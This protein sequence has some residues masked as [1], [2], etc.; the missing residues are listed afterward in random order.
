MTVFGYGFCNAGSQ[1]LRARGN[2]TKTTFLELF[3]EKLL[4]PIGFVVNTQI[5]GDSPELVEYVGMKNLINAVK[6]G[7][8]LENGKLLF[9]VGGKFDSYS[10]IKLLNM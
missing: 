4:K 6:D 8:G 9:G 3:E 5:K 1:V 7:V 10:L 2:E